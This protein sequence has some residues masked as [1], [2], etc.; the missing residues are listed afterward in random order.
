MNEYIEHLIKCRDNPAHFIENEF[1]FKSIDEQNE[2]M[3]LYDFQ[4]EMIQF[5]QSNPFTRFQ[6][7]RQMGMT[8]LI[9]AYATWFAVMHSNKNIFIQTPRSSDGKSILAMVYYAIENLN[10]PKL[11]HPKFKEQNKLSMQLDNGSRIM[12]GNSCRAKGWHIDLLLVDSA[13]F[14]SNTEVFDLMPAIS[15]LGKIIA[16]GGELD[17]P[18]MIIPWDCIPEH[19]EAWHQTMLRNIGQERFKQEYL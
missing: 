6:I 1:H 14:I 18:T 12:V 4:K 11:Y 9:A 2:P 7:A 17:F 10:M 3:K 8:T 16:N 19:D 15:T 5:I 13:N